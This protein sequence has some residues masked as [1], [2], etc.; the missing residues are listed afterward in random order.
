MNHQISQFIAATGAGGRLR[1]L[2]LTGTQ[3]SGA[4]VDM[5][6][7]T[8]DNCLDALYVGLPCS[9]GCSVGMGYLVAEGYALAADLTLC[10]CETPP[11]ICVETPMSNIIPDIEKKIKSFFKISEI[12]CSDAESGSRFCYFCT[13]LQKALA[14]FLLL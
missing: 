13:I 6:R 1:A 9:A 4:D 7:R 11:Y 2:Y 3:A 14:I 5:A 10:H 8:L 12:F